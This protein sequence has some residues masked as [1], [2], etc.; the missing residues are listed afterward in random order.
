MKEQTSSQPVTPFHPPQVTPFHIFISYD[1]IVPFLYQTLGVC[2][3]LL[4]SVQIQN[5]KLISPADKNKNKQLKKIMESEYTHISIT[6]YCDLILAIY[7]KGY[8]TR[9]YMVTFGF[10]E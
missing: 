1:S 3:Y 4:L 9:V 8:C 5:T 7:N 10:H 2:S 6:R